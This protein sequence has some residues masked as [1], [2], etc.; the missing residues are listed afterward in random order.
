MMTLGADGATLAGGCWL[1]LTGELHQAAPRPCR[2]HTAE[3]SC[4]LVAEATRRGVEAHIRAPMITPQSDAGALLGNECLPNRC[5]GP[6][7]RA[8]NRWNFSTFSFSAI[9]SSDI[10]FPSIALIFTRHE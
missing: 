5:S 8:V 10:R 7:V 6:S 3:C 1:N 9:S 4:G 2:A